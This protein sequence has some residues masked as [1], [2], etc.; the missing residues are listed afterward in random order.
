MR[1]SNKYVLLFLLAS[2]W[3]PSFIFLK[4]AVAQVQ[5]ITIACLRSVIGSI[6]LFAIVRHHKFRFPKFGTI[7]LHFLFIGLFSMALPFSLIT[8]SEKNIASALAAILNGTMPLYTIFLAFFFIKEEKFNLGKLLGLLLGFIGIFVLLLP[9]LRGT[10]NIELKSIIAASVAA[11]SYAIGAIY[12]RKKMTGQDP[13]IAPAMQLIGSSILLIPICLIFECPFSTLEMVSMKAILSILFLSIFGSAIAFILY[14]RILAIAGVSFLSN[15]TY[16]MP[17]YGVLLGYLLL[18][19]KLA[20]HT[21]AGALLILVGLLI[22]GGL[23][24]P[25]IEKLKRNFAR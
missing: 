15:V 10:Q 20:I 5:P 18:N 3:G 1:F 12:G 13:Y 7:Y 24:R 25:K 6:I 2:M 19:E 8:W 16:I 14:F 9:S 11:F 17:I 22:S 21:Y 4:I 23:I